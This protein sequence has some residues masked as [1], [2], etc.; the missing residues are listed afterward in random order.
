MIKIKQAAPA[1]AST[2]GRG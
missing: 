2:D 1:P